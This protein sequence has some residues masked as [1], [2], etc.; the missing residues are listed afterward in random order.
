MIDMW[1]SNFGEAVAKWLASWSA[2]LNVPSSNPAGGN[3][4][5][6]LVGE[7]KVTLQDSLPHHVCGPCLAKLDEVVDFMD[8]SQAT[9][10]KLKNQLRECT[11]ETI[12][13]VNEDK[14]YELIQ[15]VKVELEESD[16]QY[17]DDL[18]DEDYGP[19]S[20]KRQRRK[21]GRGLRARGANPRGQSGKQPK[22][23]KS[24]DAAHV[25]GDT[26][27]QALE[28]TAPLSTPVKAEEWM[29]NNSRQEAA[30]E[31]CVQGRL[32][33]TVNPLSSCDKLD[34][35]MKTSVRCS[36]CKSSFSQV[37]HLASHSLEAHQVAEPSYLCPQC[38]QIFSK[39]SSLK[40]HQRRK[41][42][43]SLQT[44]PQCNKLYPAHYLWTRHM[45]VH[46]NSRPFSCDKCEKKFKSKAEL[47]NHQ[48]IH[49][50]SEE[51]YTHCCEVCGKRFTQKANL[52]SHLRLHTGNRPFSCEFCGKC[53]SQ[54][55]NLEE[56]RRIHTGEKPFVCATCGVSYSRQG[57][58]A[59]H[60]RQHTGEKPH[61]CQYCEKEFLR[62]EVLKK[63]EHM[64]TDTRPYK[65]SIV[66]SLSGTKARGRCMS[67]S[68]LESVRLSV[69][70]VDEVSV[71][72]ATCGN[73]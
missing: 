5:K 43:E 67:G 13:Q 42:Q 52:D 31:A 44:C 51:R 39:I 73:I 70:F 20:T 28:N 29:E 18:N 14:L 65:C 11:T 61:K 40:N 53:F 41:H 16:R 63:H 55:G 58:L 49:R 21:A 72:P 59:M 6:S 9:Q 54:R 69:S 7:Q 68:T 46:T 33:D 27:E 47:I 62:R 38:P 24:K 8:V 35:S 36:L 60:R 23:V 48:R 4:F 15:D 12:V 45:L 37:E 1:N 10:S 57:Q 50:P 19:H 3:S 32:R 30:A 2:E 25:A 66:R 26:H 56:H 17:M 34:N 22:K 64:H 71:N